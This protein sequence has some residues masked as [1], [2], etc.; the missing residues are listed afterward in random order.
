MEGRVEKTREGGKITVTHMVAFSPS[1]KGVR[2]EVMEFACNRFM[3]TA[4]LSSLGLYAA[5]SHE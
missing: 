4:L 3:N 1:L 2:N 5:K